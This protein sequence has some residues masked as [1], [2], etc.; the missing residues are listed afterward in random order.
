VHEA[1]HYASLYLHT[2]A[3]RHIYNDSTHKLQTAAIK[4]SNKCLLC[5]FG[6]FPKATSLICEN[7]KNSVRQS[8]KFPDSDAHHNRN[9]NNSYLCSGFHFTK[10]RPNQASWQVINV[11]KHDTDAEAH[12]YRP[13]YINGL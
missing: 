5:R 13:V 1:V 8:T 4:A 7:E 6:V 2:H 11:D 9:H 3:D 12:R 10:Y